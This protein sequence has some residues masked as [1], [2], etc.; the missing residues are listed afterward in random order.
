MNRLKEANRDA[1]ESHDLL[2]VTLEEKVEL[3]SRMKSETSTLES[4]IVEKDEQIKA[5]EANISELRE[6]LE[7][8]AA[9]IEELTKAVCS[10]RKHTN[11][12]TIAHSIETKGNGIS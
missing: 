1:D 11:T 6:E 2:E 5:L 4:V 12:Q 7:R 8:N 3:E 10:T 9:Q